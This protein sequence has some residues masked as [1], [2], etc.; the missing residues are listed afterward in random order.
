M[1]LAFVVFVLRWVGDSVADVLKSLK[2]NGFLTFLSLSL[3]K[4]AK[5]LAR[6]GKPVHHVEC[7]NAFS[8]CS[9]LLGTFAKDF[10]TR[11]FHF[12]KDF[13]TEPFY[14]RRETLT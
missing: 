11:S 4:Q 1:Q 2:H 6:W 3:S 13:L 7:D 14:V 12:V 5:P 8:K 9:Q 10:L